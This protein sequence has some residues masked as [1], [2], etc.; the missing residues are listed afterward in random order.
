MLIRDPQFLT[1][2][3]H[4]LRCVLA[5]SASVVSRPAPEKKRE[6][7]FNLIKAKSPLEAT[8]VRFSRTA[9]QL[10]HVA[11]NQS[12]RRV[13]PRPT[14]QRDREELDRQHNFKSN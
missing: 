8:H 11:L 1:D 10:W 7:H 14:P 13:R 2:Y 12:R 5:K 4:F 6:M 9:I 3:S